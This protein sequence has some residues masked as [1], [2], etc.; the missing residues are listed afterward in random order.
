MASHGNETQWGGAYPPGSLIAEDIEKRRLFVVESGGRVRGVFAFII[1]PDDSY[2]VI[3]DGS[4]LSDGEYGTIHRIAGDGE[5]HG[6]VGAA[7]DFCS[8]R[9]G[10]LRIDTH[11][12]NA[13]MRRLIERNGFERRGIIHVADGSPRIAYE[14]LGG[15]NA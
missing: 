15:P 4:W 6:T 5:S 14:R 7:V 11:E 1:G 12:S 8:G 13:V 3:E 9:I 10:H 2:A